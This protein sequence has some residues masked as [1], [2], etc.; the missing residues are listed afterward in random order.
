LKGVCAKCG[1][2]LGPTVFKAGVEK[3]LQVALDMVK[4]YNV[5]DYYRQRLDLIR[6]ELDETFR[7]VEEDQ[8]QTKLLVG[9]FA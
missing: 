6:A 1:G 5:G 9:D 2:K 3:Y 8:S 4:R 7:P